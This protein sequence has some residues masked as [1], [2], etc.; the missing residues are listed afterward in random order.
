MFLRRW[1]RSAALAMVRPGHRLLGPC[2]LSFFL[3]GATASAQRAAYERP[4]IDYLNADVDDAVARLQQR[5]DDG[6]TTLAFDET[7]GYLPA[8]LGELEIPVSSQMLV[9]SKTSLQIHRISPRRPRAIYFNDDVYIGYCQKGDVLEVA[10][11]DARQG[12]TFYTLKQERT[13]RPS[14][15]RDRGGCLT[16][17]ASS[18]TQD[19][20]GYLVRSVFADAA[21]RPKFGSGTFVTDH[22]SDFRDRW[23]GWYVTGRHGSMRHMGNTLCKG[24]DTSFDRDPGANVND[25]SDFFDTDQYLSPH[26]DLVALMVMEHQ[27]QTHNAIAAANYETR[28]AL[29]QSYEMNQLLERPDGFISDSARR[30]IRAGADQVVRHLLM[31]DEFALTDSVSGT[32]DFA[33]QFQRRGPFDSRGRSLRQLDLRTRLFRYPCSYL[34]YSDAMNALPDEVRGVIYQRIADVLR[35]DDTSGD[36]DH[37]TPSIRRELAEILRET[38]P[39]FETVWVSASSATLSPEVSR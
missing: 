20:P 35:G 4:P 10:A 11:T 31:C 32:S 3:L 8:V 39:E 38:R 33:D 24:D 26:S 9:F 34:I 5:I 1:S 21:G 6:Q 36:F 19:V 7:F 16:C 28:S 2:V 25:L 17:H 14:L 22:T 37:L 29:H 23:G 12:A 13:E 18:R 15:V 30:R 27:T